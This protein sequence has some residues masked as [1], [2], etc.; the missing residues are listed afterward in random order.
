MSADASV[1]LLFGND[2]HTFRLGVGEWRELQRERKL[3]PRR[4]Y[5]RVTAGD[6]FVEDLHQIIRLGLIGGGM[7]EAEALRLTD[8]YFKVWPLADSEMIAKVVTGI[9]LFGNP[10]DPVGKAV[11]GAAKTSASPASSGTRRPRA[12]SRQSKS[13]A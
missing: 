4:L 1:D 5:D 11:A 13:T 10:D 8:T 6:W 9:G 2:R 3:G 12:A 7:A